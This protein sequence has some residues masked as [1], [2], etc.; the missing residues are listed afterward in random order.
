VA[1]LPVVFWFNVATCPGV[2]VPDTS[3][4]MTLIVE[5]RVGV[6]INPVMFAVLVS[7]FRPALESGVPL[8]D[9]VKPLPPLEAIVI[10]FPDGVSVMLDPAASVT[11]PVSEFRELTPALALGVCHVAAVPLVAVGTWPLVGVPVTVTPSMAVALLVPVPLTPILLPVGTVRLPGRM[12]AESR[13]ITGVLVELAT[14]I[15]FAVPVTA[16]TVPPPPAPPLAAHVVQDVP[17]TTLH[18]RCCPDTRL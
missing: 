15:S 9:G 10:V 12:I 1:A 4:G 5:T 13:D 3:H 18:T 6:Q 17:E 14:S 11:A 16:V 2:M 8:M 7:R